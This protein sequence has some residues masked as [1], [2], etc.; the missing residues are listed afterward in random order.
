MTDSVEFAVDVLYAVRA[1][2]GSRSL[3][4]AFDI[5]EP[6]VFSDRFAHVGA[7]LNMKTAVSAY[8][9]GGTVNGVLTPEPTP[10]RDENS[11]DDIISHGPP[12]TPSKASKENSEHELTEE[13]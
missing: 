6:D 2:L 9:L 1:G 10:S 4:H 13:L 5:D 8:G 11:V 12:S 7:E 3:P